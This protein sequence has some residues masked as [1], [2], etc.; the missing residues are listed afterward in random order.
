MNLLIVE[1]ETEQVQL[2][3]DVIDS[4]NKN[5]GT[6]INP[7]PF[8]N[9]KDA[10]NALA[11]SY[12]DAAIIDLKLSSNSIVLEGIE[13]VDSIVDKLR[14][15]V[16]IVSGSIGQVEKE[17]TAFFKKRSRDE[18][19]KAILAELLDIYN[20]GITK[21]LGKKGNIEDYL[22]AIFWDHLSISIDVWIKDKTRTSSEKE[23]AL[24]RYTLL[25]MQ[26]YISEDIQK[27]H[28]NEFYINPPIKNKL[29]T[30]DIVEY[31]KQRCLVLTPACDFAQGNV[32]NVLFVK[33]MYWEDLDLE[34]VKRPL[35]TKK[36]NKLTE[37]ITN[38]KP[39]Y[40]FIPRVNSIQAGFID[41]Q[42]KTTIDINIVN[43]RITK[44]EIKRVATVSAPFLKDIIS[45]YANYFSRQ[46]SPDFIT[47]EIL[48][49]LLI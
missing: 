35:S 27:F 17:E 4:F 21:I 9:L 32:E 44:G 6:N 49:S 22:N 14:Y 39:R 33:I 16:F 13:I 29:F 25:H 5:N 10:K 15:P 26:E 1:N 3:M 20:T 12:Y 23:K 37:L 42:Q 40:H 7:V 28:P 48:E 24:L 45:R 36:E 11:T 30:G 46:G 31:R 47:N 34:F 8:Y 2:Y 38:K 19:F 41:F 18:D 43:D